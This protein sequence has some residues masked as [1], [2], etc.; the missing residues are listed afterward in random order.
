[1]G[2]FFKVITDF[3]Q[4]SPTNF[5]CTLPSGLASADGSIQSNTLNGPKHIAIF[6]TGASPLPD[7][8][9]AGGMLSFIFNSNLLHTAIIHTFC[10][11]IMSF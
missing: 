7:G 8:F 2:V 4:V 6:L 3:T 11:T 9:G 1:M 5:V 10:Y